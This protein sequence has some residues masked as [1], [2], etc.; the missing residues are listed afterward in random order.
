M[1]VTMMSVLVV[2]LVVRVASEIVIWMNAVM[3]VMVMRMKARG[4]HILHRVP[5]QPDRRRPSELE[6]NDKH[7]DQ[8]DVAAHGSN[9]TDSRV[10]TKCP[11]VPVLRS[12]APSRF[13]HGLDK[14]AIPLKERATVIADR[15][16]RSFAADVGQRVQPGCLQ[17]GILAIER[18]FPRD[19]PPVKVDVT[20][21]VQLAWFNHVRLIEPIGDILPAEA[22]ANSY[23]KLSEQA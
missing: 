7:H 22:E 15:T 3:M 20:R 12:G 11:I 13:E 18:D 9:S 6:R 4:G 19:A 5:M 8:D 23:R 21:P 10:F 1:V 2:I 16:R 17:G 14:P